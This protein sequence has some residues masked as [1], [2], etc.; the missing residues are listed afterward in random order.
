MAPWADVLYAHDLAW[1]NA[2]SGASQFAGLKIT[3]DPVAASQWGL[4]RVALE[5][6]SD[7]L[8]LDR[9]GTIG[10]GGNSGFQALNLAVQFGARK[11]ILVGYDMRIDLGI[12]WHGKHPR[13]MN[14]PS[15]KNVERWR[16]CLDNAAEML[17]HLGIAV[18]NCSPVS[19]LSRFP[20]MS[21]EEALAC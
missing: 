2:A 21:L 4:R 3:Q 17:A 14:N 6:G 19:T 16:R 18:I 13:L 7:R 5:R 12:H 15:T 11:V 8:Q 9:P 10:S 1:W 20:K